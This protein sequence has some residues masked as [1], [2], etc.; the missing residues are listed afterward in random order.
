MWTTK[1]EEEDEDQC[2]QLG[3]FLKVFVINP[4]NKSSQNIEKHLGYFE[5]RLFLCKNG[6]DYFFGHIWG[7]FGYFLFYYLVT[8][9]RMTLCG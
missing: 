8:L 6:Y 2:D 9:M 7:R 4:S 5:S 1:F 3:Y